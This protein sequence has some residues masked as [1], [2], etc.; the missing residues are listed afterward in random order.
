VY[1]FAVAGS[2]QSTNHNNSDHNNTNRATVEAAPATTT[3]RSGMASTSACP[4]PPLPQLSTPV[5]A[6]DVVRG[7]AT[8]HKAEAVSAIR[9]ALG[10]STSE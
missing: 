8:Q 3:T 2:G 4:H 1:F 5:V 10:A 9:Q 6:A 7:G